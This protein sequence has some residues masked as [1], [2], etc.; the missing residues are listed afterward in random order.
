MYCQKC[1]E[2]LLEND[3]YCP[4]CGTETTKNKSYSKHPG[5]KS[6]FIALGLVAALLFLLVVISTLV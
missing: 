4:K 5:I 3:L 2:I 1:G 6:L